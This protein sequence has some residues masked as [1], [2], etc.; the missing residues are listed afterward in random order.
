MSTEQI[1]A[2]VTL[3]KSQVYYGAPVFLTHN[4]DEQ[5]R[6]AVSLSGILNAMVHD[7]GNGTYVL[8]KH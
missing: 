8:V 1:L 6:M 7:L 5:E 3:D 2:V 4:E